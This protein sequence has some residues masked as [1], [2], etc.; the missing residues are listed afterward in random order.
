MSSRQVDS[1]GAV[2][3]GSVEASGPGTEREDLLESL[4][5]R[6][7][8]GS[9]AVAER[10][11]RAVRVS[12]NA[13]RETREQNRFHVGVAVGAFAVLSLVLAPLLWSSVDYLCSGGRFGDMTTQMA[14]LILLLFAT[15]IG[16]LIA[17]W[18]TRATSSDRDKA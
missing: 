17:G 2:L 12:A 4:A 3:R 18:K 1:K 7:A 8:Q 14:F 16:A 15:T 5:G 6:N 13:R 10:T 11:R 9:L